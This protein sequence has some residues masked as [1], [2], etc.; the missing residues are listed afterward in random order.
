MEPPVCSL[1]GE[2]HGVLL[3]LAKAHGVVAA[4][5]GDWVVF[6]GYPARLRGLIYD[7]TDVHPMCSTQVDI[8]F[9]P[10]PGCLVC[11]SFA[12]L[13]ETR[14]GRIQNSLLPD[15]RR[16]TGGR[17]YAPGAALLRPA[18]STAEYAGVAARQPA[19]D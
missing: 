14:A 17:G 12:G 2:L 4:T 19:L 1:P 10:W 18:G 13:A 16:A 11:E 8:R 9:S 15:A 5:E 6:P 3:E 7:L